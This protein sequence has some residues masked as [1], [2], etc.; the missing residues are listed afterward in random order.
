M[1][2]IIQENVW[3]NLAQADITPFILDAILQTA[4]D[5]GVGSAYAEV[6]A[7]I[8]VTLASRNVHGVAGKVIARLRRAISSSATKPTSDLLDH[9]SMSEIQILV[10]F[11]LMLSFNNNLMIDTHLPEL[12]YIVT[13]LAGTGNLVLRSSVHGIVVNIVQTLCTNG[14]LS[15]GRVN[16]LKVILANFTEVLRGF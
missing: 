12:W 14:R 2:P 16:M 15:G 5:N 3:I 1:F 10:R 9:S 7:N 11:I 8:A 6:A 4:I 13:M